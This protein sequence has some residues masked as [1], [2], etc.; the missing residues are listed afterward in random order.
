MDAPTPADLSPKCLTSFVGET[1]DPS[2]SEIKEWCQRTF[3]LKKQKETPAE[4]SWTRCG[5]PL[6]QSPLRQPVVF[7]LTLFDVGLMLIWFSFTKESNPWCSRLDWVGVVLSG[8]PRE[9]FFTSGDPAGKPRLWHVFIQSRTCTTCCFSFL[10]LQNLNETDKGNS[11]R[12]QETALYCRC[13][14]LISICLSTFQL[15]KLVN[16]SFV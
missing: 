10:D 7:E 3:V 14:K 9:V 16:L 13:L 1:G 6:R 2:A 5:M 12:A 8:S 4:L 11:S 15:L